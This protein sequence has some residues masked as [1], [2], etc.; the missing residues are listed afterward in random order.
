M[1]GLQ[2][3]FSAIIGPQLPL[4]DVKSEIIMTL[5]IFS[6]QSMAGWTEPQLGFST[7]HSAAQHACAVQ[8]PHQSSEP[9]QRLRALVTTSIPMQTMNMPCA[10][11]APQGVPNATR[12]TAEKPTSVDFAATVPHKRTSGAV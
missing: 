7:M 6:H 11:G 2:E 4:L 5:L 3:T 1:T 9:L 10:S 8:G 12:A